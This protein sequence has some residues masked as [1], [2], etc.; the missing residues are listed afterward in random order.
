MKFNQLRCNYLDNPLGTSQ[1]VV[2]TWNYAEDYE[3]DIKQTSFK[4][5]ISQSPEF[6]SICYTAQ[7]DTDSMRHEVNAL[8]EPETKY[9]WRVIAAFQNGSSL[10]SP[11]AEFET[12]LSENA[13][14]TLNAGW[15]TT[16]E[17]VEKQPKSITF[18]LSKTLSGIVKARAYVFGAGFTQL[19]VNQ[20]V[21]DEKLLAPANTP[22][23]QFVY[24]DVYDITEKLTKGKNTF[25]VTVAGGYNADYLQFGFRFL[26]K[27]GARVIIALT[28][29]KG[30]NSY[31]VSDK[32]WRWRENQITQ[33]SIYHGETYDARRTNFSLKQ[34]TIEEDAAPKG[35][36]LPNQMPPITIYKT[37]APVSCHIENDG[38]RVYDFGGNESGFVKIAVEAPAGTEI[39]MQHSELLML[40]GHIS[41]W[42]N[43]DAKATDTY[44]CSGE[45]VEVYAPSTTY[46]G[47]RYVRV[48]GLD[49]AKSF[50]IT[51]CRISADVKTT[52]HF[53]CSDPMIN[54][55]QANVV[56]S[57]RSNLVSIPT[58]CNMRNERTPCLMDSMVVEEAATYNFDMPAYY[59]KWAADIAGLKEN[60]SPDW[61][62]DAISVAWRLYKNC[63]DPY[64]AQ[65]HY[66]DYDRIM[67]IL[68][69][70]SHDY[71]FDFPTGCGDW[72]H[73]NDNTWDTIGG[74]G[75]SIQSALFYS[76]AKMMSTFAEYL[77]KKDDVKFYEDLAEKISAEFAKR[78]V[79][80]NGVCKDGRQ[81]SMLIPL[82]KGIVKGNLADKVYR[83][84][85]QKMREDKVL[86]VG[87]FGMTALIDVPAQGGNIDDVYRFFQTS[88][89][90]SFGYQLANGAKSLWEEWAYTGVMHSHNHAMFSSVSASFYKNFA[91][92]RPL[93]PGFRRFEVKP[94]LPSAMDYSQAEVNTVSGKIAVKT[95]KFK[96]D[97]DGRHDWISMYVTVPVNTS[98]EVYIPILNDDT[99]DVMFLDGDR[100]LN[101]ASFEKANGFYHITVGS[102]KYNFRII[103]VKFLFLDTNVKFT[104]QFVDE[105]GNQVYKEETAPY[106]TIITPPAIAPVKKGFRFVG[107]EGWYEGRFLAEGNTFR[108]KFE[109]SRKKK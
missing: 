26:G 30:N 9:Y 21:C 70:D 42:T 24:Y 108:A 90:P 48:Q 100:Q 37:E 49:K 65:V 89:W 3:R 103:P 17:P 40:D 20:Q 34:V 57:L 36:L 66:D 2:L 4:I 59:R 39:V 77:G 87:I 32:S 28:D 38:A 61:C 60:N 41:A 18:T 76:F 64:A 45:G 56:R 69:R 83:A 54:E 47:F 23:N 82:D 6:S 25:D 86:D 51:A 73:P 13:W 74:N 62:T 52:G 85:I 50:E 10:T 5:E 94:I 55:I 92:L 105:D 11:V 109:P 35:T 7:A 44:I 81:A 106:G 99:V 16:K 58:D 101:P 19:S 14:T 46:H 15:M 96:G 80:D 98:A 29:Q 78:L 93:A 95:E 53:E 88:R 12:A 22:Y 8:L 75:S 72:C 31:V 33:T 104:Y 107:W 27:R 68:I 1:Q 63:G 43:R 84:L 97:S 71:L 67:K 91:G 79:D 102:G